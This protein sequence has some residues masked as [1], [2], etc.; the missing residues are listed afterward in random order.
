MKAGDTARVL[1]GVYA[2]QQGLVTATSAESGAVVIQLGKL[3]G[4]FA[5]GELEL[6]NRPMATVIDLEVGRAW[7]AKQG[8]SR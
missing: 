4:A 2:G 1:V 8:G 5:D 6:I 7:L 3:R